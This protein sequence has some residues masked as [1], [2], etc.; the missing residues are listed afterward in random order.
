MTIDDTIILAVTGGG[1]E[2]D[3]PY[4]EGMTEVVLDQHQDQHQD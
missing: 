2:K 3:T 4:L 1:Q